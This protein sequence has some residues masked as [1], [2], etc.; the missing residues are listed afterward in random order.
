MLSIKQLGARSMAGVA[1]LAIAAV[2]TACSSSGA[3]TSGVA[4]ASGTPAGTLAPAGAGLSGTVTIDGSSTVY[5]ITE[6]VAE[7]FQ[8]AN[9]GVKVTVAFAGTGG[10]FKKFCNGETDMNDAS[11]PIKKDDAGEGQA[12]TAKNIGY[13]ELG[14]ATDALSVVV[15]KDN[16][17]AKCLTTAQLKTMWDQGSAAKSWKDIDPTFP[18]Q[19]LKL[20]GP[21]PDSGTFDYFT[22]VINGKAK[23][24]RS[25][26]TPSEDD[27]ALVTGVAGDNDALGYF[28]FAY[29]EANLDKIKAVAVD[30]GA[31]CVEPSA[32]NVNN[33]TYK[34][35]ARPLFIYPSVSALK[36]PE[37]AAFV[38]Y[39]LDNVNTYVDETGYI[40]AQPDVLA[41]SKAD[42]A[43]ATR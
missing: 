1:V 30:S 40:E 2:S 19:P 8:K 14:I 4:G 3:P 11:R 41:K 43:A 33:G 5:P 25:D 26:Y 22:E 36:R 21:G 16:S 7:E 38:Q 10:G 27:N 17:W 23:Q 42:V 35:L 24:S 39:Y 28:G 15:N 9:P 32:D 12:C 34:P 6:A 29:L 20:F 31:G 18:D 37:F 13:V